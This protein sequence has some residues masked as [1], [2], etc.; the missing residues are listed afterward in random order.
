MYKNILLIS[1]FC[2]GV[3]F[4][5]C[6]NTKTRH[7]EKLVK[8]WQGKEIIFPKNSVFTKF[9]DDTIRLPHNQYDYT[10]LMY[11]DS[12]GCTACKLKLLYWKDFMDQVDSIRDVNI[13]YRFYFNP[14]N[15]SEV[16]FL[17]RRYDCEVPV[18]LDRKD[19]I[20]KINHF[21]NNIM[22]QTFLLNKENKVVVMGNPVH[23]KAVGK[24]YLKTMRKEKKVK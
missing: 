15:I 11:V 1:V 12:C 18:C 13:S 23:N 21:P 22:F 4:M 7:I 17:L 9:G 8:E 14:K 19:E 6:K 2:I 16:R 20:N 10:I 3:L 24:L 5:S